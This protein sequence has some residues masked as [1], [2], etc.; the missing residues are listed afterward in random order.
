MNSF[1]R[2]KHWQFRRRYRAALTI[3]IASYTYKT[4]SSEDQGRISNWVRNLIDGKFN[5]AFSFKE[6]ELFLPMHAKAA[7]WAVAMKSLGIPPAVPGEIWR[8]PPQPRWLS[9]FGVANKLIRDWRPFN[10]ITTQV[11]EFLKSK[12]VDVSTIDL[13]TR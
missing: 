5:P 1:Q 6:F 11:Q 13:Q 8:I 3:Y 4:L 7:F 12:G 9:R 2:L 10:A